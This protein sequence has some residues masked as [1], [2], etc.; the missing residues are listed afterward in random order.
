MP[1]GMAIRG[2]YGCIMMP[3]SCGGWFSDGED[4]DEGG[5]AVFGAA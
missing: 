2:W 4:M 1:F 3:L 5:E